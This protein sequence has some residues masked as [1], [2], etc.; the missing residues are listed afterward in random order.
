MQWHIK[1]EFGGDPEI[2]KGVSY[3]RE[4]AHATWLAL[5]WFREKN[6]LAASAAWSDEQA[7]EFIENWIKLDKPLDRRELALKALEGLQ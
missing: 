2:D 3:T 7:Y 4:A 5:K 1:A 6:G